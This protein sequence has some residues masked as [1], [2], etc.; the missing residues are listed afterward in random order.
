MHQRARDTGLRLAREHVRDELAAALSCDLG[1]E[2]VGRLDRSVHPHEPRGKFGPDIGLETQGLIRV[3][4][5]DR[6]QVAP[7]GTDDVEIRV[8][9]GRAAPFGLQLHA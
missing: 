2:A 1:R 9:R 3:C 7:L 4:Q 5:V 6:R 8:R